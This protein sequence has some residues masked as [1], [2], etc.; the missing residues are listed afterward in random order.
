MSRTLKDMPYPLRFAEERGIRL[1]AQ[2]YD[3][4]NTGYYMSDK[5]RRA[6][7]KVLE[8]ELDFSYPWLCHPPSWFRRDLNRTE[9]A[10]ANQKVRIGDYDGIERHRRNARWLWW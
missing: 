7:R 9:R 2:E 8:E 1:S 5:S 4:L 3:L 6:A 10:K